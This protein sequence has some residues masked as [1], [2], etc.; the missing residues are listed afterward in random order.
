MI[1]TEIFNKVVADAKEKAGSDKKWQNAIDR[2]AREILS[3]EMIVS[4]FADNTALITTTNGQ[5]RVNGHCGCK[6]AQNNHAQCAHRAAKKL[7]TL[8]E[9]AACK[10]ALPVE[11][12]ADVAT[13]PRKQLIVEINAAWPKSWP[14]LYTELLAR[15]GKSDLN[16]LDDDSLR[17]VRLAIAI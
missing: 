6:A 8:Y 4:L 2:A 12:R 16:Q 1:N 7:W 5:Y 13:T 14:P 11:F 17:G 10:A 15:F 3:G 9:E